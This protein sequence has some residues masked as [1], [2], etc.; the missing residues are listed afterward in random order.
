M[1]RTGKS[2]ILSIEELSNPIGSPSGDT[3][4][5]QYIRNLI[6]NYEVDNSLDSI[7]CHYIARRLRWA[8]IVVDDAKEKYGTWRV[9][10]RFN[11]NS[12]HDLTHNG[13]HY[14]QYTGLL[15]K[16]YYFTYPIQSWVLSKVSTLILP[17]QKKWYRH[18][19][20]KAI[21]K[22]PE[23]AKAI[24]LGADGPDLLEGL[25]PDFYIYQTIGWREDRSSSTAYYH[26]YPDHRYCNIITSHIVRKE[27]QDARE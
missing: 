16:L 23:E 18:V 17:L 21:E 24:L 22:F 15:L 12:V 4:M 27:E 10:V 5:L 11:I 26:K 9:Y 13:Y 20:K 1:F 14:I 19:H 6:S 8:G 2:D 3:P 7:P 25:H